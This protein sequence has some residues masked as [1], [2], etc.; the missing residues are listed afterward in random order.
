VVKSFLTTL[1]TELL[2][3]AHPYPIRQEV[4]AAIFEYVEGFYRIALP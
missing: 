3:K 2:V 1:K 4:R